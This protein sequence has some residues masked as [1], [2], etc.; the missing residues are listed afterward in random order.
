MHWVSRTRAS[1]QPSAFATKYTDRPLIK[2]PFGFHFLS[3]EV[4]TNKPLPRVHPPSHT[5]AMYSYPPGIN[6]TRRNNR[7]PHTKLQGY[8][9]QAHLGN[10][11]LS[12]QGGTHFSP[13]TPCDRHA[14][15]AFG[16]DSHPRITGV[17]LVAVTNGGSPRFSSGRAMYPDWWNW[18]GINGNRM[19]FGG[20]AETENAHRSGWRVLE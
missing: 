20:F 2:D 4:T 18:T 19:I 12:N 3:V 16:E 14:F 5:Q 8:S 7:L 11:I 17:S 15:R 1:I 13:A 9:W 10:K 6:P